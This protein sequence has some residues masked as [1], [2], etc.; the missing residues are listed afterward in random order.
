VKPEAGNA[1]DDLHDSRYVGRAVVLE[2]L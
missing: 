2:Q 1:R